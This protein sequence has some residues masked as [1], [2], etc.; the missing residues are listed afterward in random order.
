VDIWLLGAIC[1]GNSAQQRQRPIRKN[2][3]DIAR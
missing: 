3:P 2:R 1:T